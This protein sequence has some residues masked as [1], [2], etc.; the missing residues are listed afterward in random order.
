MQGRDQGR[1]RAVQYTSSRTREELQS[2]PVPTPVDLGWPGSEGGVAG[3][4]AVIAPI[5]P[6]LVTGS[7]SCTKGCEYFRNE[8]FSDVICEILFDRTGLPPPPHSG[9]GRPGSEG[10]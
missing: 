2:S 5:R 1:A 3:Y 8:I 9:P 4:G 10:G 7:G 6:A